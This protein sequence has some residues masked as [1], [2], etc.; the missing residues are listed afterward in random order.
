MKYAI[1]LAE[2]VLDQDHER[3]DFISNCLENNENPMIE[4][5]N[6]NHIYSKA[7]HTVNGGKV[8]N[9]LAELFDEEDIEVKHRIEFYRSECKIPDECKV[10]LLEE[11]YELLMDNDSVADEDVEALS[12]NL[13]SMCD[14][15]EKNL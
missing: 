11:L 9:C 1:D 5:L 12:N 10:G 6:Y 4:F 14:L 8:E 13:S 7:V 2:Y 15:Y 3:K